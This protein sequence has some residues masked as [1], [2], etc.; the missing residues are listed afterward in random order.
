VKLEPRQRA[1]LELGLCYR[2]GEDN[3]FRGR[4]SCFECLRKQK[5]RCNRRYEA[6]K[7]AGQVRTPE[8]RKRDADYRRAKSAA[9]RAAGLCVGCGETAKRFRRCT[10]CRAKEAQRHVQLRRAA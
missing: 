3:T 4:T 5:E 8:Q 1:R 10:R 7:A 9:R 6:L 2:C